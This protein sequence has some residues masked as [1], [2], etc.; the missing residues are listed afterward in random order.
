MQAREG[1]GFKREQEEICGH[2]GGAQQR[3]CEKTRTCVLLIYLV[4]AS[5]VVAFASS[6]SLLQSG[7]DPRAKAVELWH[8]LPGAA[9]LAKYAFGPQSKL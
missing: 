4:T 2:G 5:I 7:G 1:E 3:A 8:W 6:Q 9:E